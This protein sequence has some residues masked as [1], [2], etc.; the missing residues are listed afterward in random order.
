MQTL[1]PNNDEIDGAP[2]VNHD[3]TDDE[4]DVY[5][6]SC[7]TRCCQDTLEVIQVQDDGIIM[8]KTRKVQ[9]HGQQFCIDWFKKFPWLILCTTRFK[10]YCACCR[11]SYRQSLL[12]DKL[13]KA[14]FVTMGFGNW[15]KGIQR[16]NQHAFSNMHKESLLKI[17]LLKI[18]PIDAQINAKVKK[19]QEDHGEM[20]LMVIESLKY[21]LRQGLA[22]RGHEE[23]DGNLM[24]LLSLQLF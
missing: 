8:S 21:L 24:Q 20:L 6:E 15:K 17:E 16:L 9:G 5:C 1:E 19:D 3:E 14:A 10:A 12:P 23:K 2:E 7:S 4:E 22:I 11:Y 18:V 13:G